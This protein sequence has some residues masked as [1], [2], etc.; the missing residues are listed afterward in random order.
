MEPL[1]I[2][3][4]GRKRRTS[5][6]FDR[7]LEGSEEEEVPEIAEKNLPGSNI[8]P[9]TYAHRK[10]FEEMQAIQ[11]WRREWKGFVPPSR[12]FN[13]GDPSTLG[14]YYFLLIDVGETLLTL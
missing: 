1:S 8:P 11:Y 7:F 12:Q 6:G 9:H 14:M 13:I 4:Y 2:L 10:E 5:H 3:V